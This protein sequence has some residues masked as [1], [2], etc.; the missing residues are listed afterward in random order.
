MKSVLGSQLNSTPRWPLNS[1][2]LPQITVLSNR[3]M[4]SGGAWL[5][6]GL[7]LLGTRESRELVGQLGLPAF[8]TAAVLIDGSQLYLE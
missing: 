2:V 6:A 7:L 4:I 1:C 3:P 5:W 8:I